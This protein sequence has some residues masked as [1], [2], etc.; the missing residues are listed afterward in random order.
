MLLV[1]CGVP[2]RVENSSVSEWAKR[3][4]SKRARTA[5]ITNPEARPCEA[6]GQSW[7]DLG[8]GWV[9]LCGSRSFQRS[10]TMV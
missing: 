9:L 10:A 2:T 7:G 3:S 5:R 8:G 4:F 6:S 1:V